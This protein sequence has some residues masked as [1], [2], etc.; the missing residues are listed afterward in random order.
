MGDVFAILADPTRRRMLDAMRV[1][2]RS[3]GELVAAVDIE[4]PGDSRHLRIM[5]EAGLVRVR[6]EGQRRLYSLQPEPLRDLDDW[7]ADFRELWDGRFDRMAAHIAQTREET[8]D[9][10][11]N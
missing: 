11:R 6:P 3:V 2:E 1:G 8:D 9:D 10:N 4:Q 7:L 5:R